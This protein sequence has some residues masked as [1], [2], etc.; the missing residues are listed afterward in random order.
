M[1]HSLLCKSVIIMQIIINSENKNLTISVVKDNIY[2]N[3]KK[4]RLIPLPSILHNKKIKNEYI[5]CLDLI[6]KNLKNN[7][8]YEFNDKKLFNWLNI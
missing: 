5:S 6:H 4:Q 8:E 2:I 7:K 3:K 1:I